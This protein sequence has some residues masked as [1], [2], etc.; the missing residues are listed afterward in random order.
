MG[1]GRSISWLVFTT[2]TSAIDGFNNDLGLNNVK[3]QI[4]YGSEQELYNILTDLYE[5]DIITIGEVGM[6]C[7][8]AVV[9]QKAFFEESYYAVAI[10]IYVL[11]N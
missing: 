9:I 1:R 2:N 6:N 8:Y 7:Y 3:S 4:F 5:P 11:N 10:K